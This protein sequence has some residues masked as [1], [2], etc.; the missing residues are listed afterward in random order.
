MAAV[1][2]YATTTARAQTWS[3]ATESGT[4]TEYGNSVATDNA[5]N[6]YIAGDYIGPSTFGTY[7]LSAHGN[8]DA[9]LAKYNSSGSVVWA[10][11]MAGSLF[12]YGREVVVDAGSNILVAGTYRGTIT[13]YST[14]GTTTTSLTGGSSTDNIYLAKYNSSGIVQWAVPVSGNADCGGLAIVPSQLKV[15]VCGQRLGHLFAASYNYAGST[16]PSAPTWTLSAT[17][18]G[19]SK[20]WAITGDGAGNSY[21]LSTYSGTVTGT[22]STGG[23]FSGVDGML[24]TKISSAGAITWSVNIGS[25]AA[26]VEQGRGIRWNPSGHLYIG[27]HFTG[28]ASIAGSSLS[29][30]GS[31]DVFVAKYTDGGGSV[32][33]RRMG[34]TGGDNLRGFTTNSAG[35]T[36]LFTQS[37]DNNSVTFGCK[38]YPAV[39]GN[40]D[41]K[42]ILAKYNSG[43]LVKGSAALTLNNSASYPGEV[44]LDA[45]GNTILTGHK[46]GA[47]SAGPYTLSTGADMF[48]TK[49]L[50]ADELPTV[51]S[52][53][54]N[55]CGLG[56]S[57][58]L[59]ASGPSGS[60]I[61]WYNSAMTLLTTGGSYT[62]PG[63]V[64]YSSVVYYVSSTVGGCESA[65]LSVT[66]TTR[67]YNTITA[68]VS[69][70]TI[71]NGSCVTV[72]FANATTAILMPGSVVKTSPFVICPS[73][74]TN[75]T[76]TNNAGGYCEVPGTFTIGVVVTDPFAGTF[77][78]RIAV[79]SGSGCTPAITAPS[80]PGS[81]TPVINTATMPNVASNVLND[82]RC[83]IGNTTGWMGAGN[84]G[85]NN[86]TF[87]GSYTLD[88]YEVEVPSGVRKVVGSTLAPSVFIKYGNS[89]GTDDMRFNEIGWGAGFVNTGPFY[90]DGSADG[91]GNNGNGD[92]FR[93]FYRY[94]YDQY[95]ATTTTAAFD[96][97]S[98]RVFCIDMKQ[99][100]T[101]GGCTISKKTYF[102]IA[103]D[104]DLNKNNGSGARMAVLDDESTGKEEEY[105]S[106]SI[107]PNPTNS[108]VYIP[109]AADDKNVQV[110][111]T[112]NLG[113]QVMKINNFESHHG[114]LNMTSLP[115]GIYFYNIL[116][117]NT[118]YK[119]KIMKQ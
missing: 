76:L 84:A 9:F 67:P 103:Y 99:I 38:T 78:D 2:L 46:V 79:P 37:V 69:T 107:Y 1:A 80:K 18:T 83:A 8:G 27:G 116:K 92:Y 61:K 49:V 21:L 87:V 40:T 95:T 16:A 59:S 81:T 117:N 119:G 55:L 104:T 44:S 86:L 112:D 15:Y 7:T 75:Y 3:W 47:F 12:D 6:N 91:D 63:A 4:G 73:S 89:D 111:I 62:T 64:A 82:F 57:T 19:S 10:V 35:D 45:S 118:T 39:F 113:K 94:C 74:T 41:N 68:S 53:D 42:M 28:T 52:T 14:D 48:L 110:I 13:F 100:S 85:V 22:L 50:I 24:M 77:S 90:C 66:V 96:D 20:A 33:A 72:T 30:A 11:K 106:L 101:S 34:G 60:T 71:C 43:G 56:A 29:S 108:L 65:R 109:L 36:Y 58:T 114:E 88:V 51:A 102:R 5:G 32:W 70:P 54:V 115:A 17:G 105:L 93:E 26:G 25:G 97:F 23:T 31:S 98:S